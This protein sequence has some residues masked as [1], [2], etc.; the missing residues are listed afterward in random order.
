MI[1][2]VIKECLS[3]EL[4]KVNPELLCRPVKAVFVDGLDAFRRKPHAHPSVA[5]FPEELPLLEVQVLHLSHVIGGKG[6]FGEEFVGAWDSDTI[7][8]NRAITVRCRR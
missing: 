6:T 4:N 8:S 1:L 2:F 5:L 7:T 3:G